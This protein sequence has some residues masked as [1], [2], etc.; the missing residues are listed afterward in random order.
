MSADASQ[1]GLGAVLLQQHKE[2]LKPIAYC[3]R[4]LTETETRYAQIEKEL[5]E[6]HGHVKDLKSIWL[7]WSNL[8][9]TRIT[10]LW[11]R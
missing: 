6:T 3:S 4:T 7:A 8:R 5:L 9:Y 2:G 1:F 10:S 11:F